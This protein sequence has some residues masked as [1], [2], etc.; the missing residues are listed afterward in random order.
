MCPR[1]HS[2]STFI[3]GVRNDGHAAISISEFGIHASAGS[4]SPDSPATGAADS[5]TFVSLWDSPSANTTS[6]FRF[7]GAADFSPASPPATRFFNLLRTL[8]SLG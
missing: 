2:I 6:A 1:K 4:G 5:V 3:I 8:I 7:T